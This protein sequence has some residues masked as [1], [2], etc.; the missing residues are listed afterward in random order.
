MLFEGKVGIVTGG[1]SGIGLAIVKGFLEEGAKVVVA[2]WA[3]NGAEV[4]ESLGYGPDRVAFFRVDVSSEEQTIDL[5]QFTVEKFS[6]LDIAIANAG[7]AR[8]KNMLEEDLEGW[9]KVMA[10][11]LDG[12]FLTDK[13][14]IE[15]MLRQ[16][17]P[18]AV[19]NNSSIGGIVG[20]EDYLAYSAAKAGVINLTRCLGAGYADKG[21]RVNAVA[22]GYIDT[23]LMKNASVARRE[24]MIDKHPI[25]RFATPE[26]VA[27]AVIFLASDKASYITGATLSVDGGYTAV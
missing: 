15:Q 5:I 3:E 16:G 20:I 7:I 19:V 13:Y 1:C 18:G 6:K 23:P 24:Y 27:N 8:V 12:V 21:I 10:V 4:V 17:T 2:D 22:P 14:A 11:D 25:H 26:E 9:R